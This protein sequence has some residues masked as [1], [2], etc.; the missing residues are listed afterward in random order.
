MRYDR[1]LACFLVLLSLQQGVAQ[2]VL[3]SVNADSFAHPP[4]SVGIRCWWWWLNGNVTRQS[5]TRDLEAMK[6]K[7]FSG[8]SI[9]DAGGYDQWGNGPVPE[10]PLFGSPA[11]RELYEHAVK[12]AHRLGLVLSLNI[13]SGWNLGA[14]DVQPQEATKHITWSETVIEGNKP[15][16]LQLSQPPSK[17]HF[18]RDIAVLALPWHDTAGITALNNLRQKAAFNEVGGSAT[19]TRF[20][21][22]NG[23]KDNHAAQ[24]LYSSR[25]EKSN[26]VIST[27]N[28]GKA[29]ARHQEV[30]DI[31]RLMD[32]T[33]TLRWNAPPGKWVIMR[34]GYTNSGARIS[35]SSGKWKGLVIDYMS[36]A[37]FNRYWDTHVK[38]LLESI[39]TDAGTT[40]RYLQTDSWELDGINWTEQFREEFRQRRGYDLLPYL[41]VVAGKIIDHPDASN[42]FLNDLRKTISDCIADNHYKVFQQRAAA[43]GIGIQPES[44]GPHAGPFDGLKNFGHS[45]I[46]MGE[47]WSPSAHRPV[48]TSRFFVKQAASAAHIY[49][50]PLVGA[51][52][53]T[54]IGRHWNDVIWE[55]MKSSFD[56]EVCEGLNLTLLHTFTSSPAEM[57]LP[58]QEYFAGTH[59]N[60][61]IT[62]W[63]YADAFFSYMARIQYMM[64]QGQFVADV[65][66]YYGDHVPNIA[67]LKADDPAGALPGFD[68]DVINEDRLLALDVKDGWLT[69]PHGMHY[70]VLVLPGHKV[71]SLAALKKVDKLV[72]AGAVVIGTSVNTTASLV[73][74][75][76]SEQERAVLVNRLW[77]KTTTTKGSRRVGKG[78]IAWGY[79]AAEWLGKAGTAPDCAVQAD[80]A[81]FSFPYIH[82][83]QDQTDYYFISNQQPVATNARFTF[84]VSGKQPE[85]WNPVTGNTIPAQ[86]FIQ[87]NGLTTIPVPFTPFG[88]WLVVFREK[89]PVTQ[90]GVAASND[91]P[92]IPLDTLRGP[93][94]VH[95]DTAWGGPDKVVFPQLI[96]WTDRPEKGIREYSGS[97]V[98][99]QT[100]QFTGDTNEP[101]FIDLGV[102]KDVGIARVFL[103]GQDLGVVWAPPLQVKGMLKTGENTITIEVINSWRNRLV[104]DRNLPAAQRFTQT[105]ITIRPE[106]ELLPAGLLGPVVIGKK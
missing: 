60:P 39:G 58:G 28:N 10:G 69:L 99:R 16:V 70:R 36:A 42:Y 84:R 90:Q 97:A 25:E 32:S 57:G 1:L 13:Q 59:F 24:A 105:N 65:L 104:G 73:G 100:F 50:K 14:P 30:K 40:L 95:F 76:A 61:N 8:A 7:G 54:T 6:E 106:W 52:S 56:H 91:Y 18:Y 94:E 89:I 102:V 98:Y 85:L 20:L 78:Q 23:V 35:T 68:Y 64:Q 33:G 5:I 55:H 93:W 41:P 47:F 101:A 46:M 2:Q 9:V 92:F 67:R 71:L 53:F 48:A 15:I 44:A 11:W 86:A 87:T 4:A 81:S 3:P 26:Y 88:S 82:H 45:D 17:L 74:G 63:K 79:T 66:Y 80:S 77:G 37:H 12:E 103:N 22:S 62:W 96:S 34:F 83:T 49:N 75:A 72:Q 21:L 51:E 19:D 43:Y 27:E 29:H 38:P 31:S